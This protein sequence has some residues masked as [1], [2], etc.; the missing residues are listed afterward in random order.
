MKFKIVLTKKGL[1]IFKGGNI[2]PMSKPL[3]NFDAEN[4]KEAQHIYNKM[5]LDFGEMSWG[6]YEL[7]IVQQVQK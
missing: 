1:N 2:E 3:I 4:I 5:S 7:K 6:Y